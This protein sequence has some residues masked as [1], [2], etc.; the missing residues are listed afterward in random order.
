M[1]LIYFLD[2]GWRSIDRIAGQGN[3]FEISQIKLDK[4]E[5]CYIS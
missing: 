2:S 3:F 1:I 4:R 5:N